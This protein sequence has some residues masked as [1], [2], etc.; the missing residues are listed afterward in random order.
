MFDEAQVLF[1]DHIEQLRDLVYYHNIPVICYVLRTDFRSKLFSGSMRLMELANS[2][3]EVKTTC[4]YCH[5]KAV[6]S[7]KH[8]N[9]KA[10]IEGPS[11]QLETEERYLPVCYI[12]AIIANSKKSLVLT[13]TMLALL[14]LHRRPS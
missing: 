9:G 14:C 8:V 12:L 13:I 4:F 10:T 11:V 1:S 6:L 2:I 5:R 7:L 3:E